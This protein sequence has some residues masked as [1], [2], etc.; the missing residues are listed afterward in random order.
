MNEWMN[1]WMNE[2]MNERMNEWMNEGMN[3][4]EEEKLD[5]FYFVSYQFSVSDQAKSKCEYL[6]H[7][8]YSALHQVILSW[9]LMSDN[10]QQILW[11]SGD[12]CCSITKWHSW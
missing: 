6:K 7:K 5:K 12:W 2:R 4:E 9:C 10:K 3:E 8:H 1:E 11:E